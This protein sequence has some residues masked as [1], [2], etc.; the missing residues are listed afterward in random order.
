L[1]H[2][3]ETRQSGGTAGKL[4]TGDQIV[5]TFDQPISTAS[6]PS[7]TNTVCSV[8]GT[9]IVLGA[10]ATTGTCSA[11]ETNNL[12]TLKNGSANANARWAA[13]WVWSNA[14]KTLTITLGTRVQGSAPTISGT[15]SFYPVTTAT[16]LLSATG[17]FHICD[18]NTGGG[19]CLPTLTGSF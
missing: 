7:G 17:S 4:D 16:K 14:N 9:T 1:D 19:N 5:V 18:T 10:T 6:G 3:G 8:N 15:W 13:T 12:G 2:L 11:S